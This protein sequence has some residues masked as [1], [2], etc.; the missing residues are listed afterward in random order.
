MIVQAIVFTHVDSSV[1]TCNDLQKSLE[2]CVVSLVN[3]ESRLVFRHLGIFSAMKF[4]HF[5]DSTGPIGSLDSDRIAKRFFCHVL[6]VKFEKIDT[7]RVTVMSAKIEL[8][9]VGVECDIEIATATF[10]KII[11]TLDE[12]EKRLRCNDIRIIAQIREIAVLRRERRN[13]AECEVL[14][15]S[16]ADADH[17]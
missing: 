15:L 6:D 12:F 9:L 2:F 17:F 3:D 7:L 14:V 4:V 13:A 10:D 1:E 11:E 16:F 5:L 8:I